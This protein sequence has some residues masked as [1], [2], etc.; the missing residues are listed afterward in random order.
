MKNIEIIESKKLIEYKDALDFMQERINLIKKK[1]STELIWFLEHPSIFTIG[2]GYHINKISINKIPIFKTNRGGKITW[3]GP[4]QRIIYFAIDIKKRNI[5]IRKFVHDIEKFIIT[6]LENIN[7]KAFTRKDLIG[8][9]TL[10]KEKKNAKIG[11]LGLRVSKG[12]IYHGVSLN[13]SCDLKNFYQIDPCGIANSHVTSIEKI[14]G[15]IKMKYIDLILKKNL[16]KL[17]PNPK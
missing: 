17:I 3:H 12:I 11:S 1:K 15:P 14:I 9:W 5:D 7:I 6:S 8:I 16:K 10:N 13:I 2:S 4:G